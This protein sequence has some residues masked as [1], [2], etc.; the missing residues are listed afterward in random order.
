MNDST[1]KKVF[2]V[3]QA[4]P[5]GYHIRVCNNITEVGEVVKEMAAQIYILDHDAIDFRDEQ[6]MIEYT[7]DNKYI[8]VDE[9]IAARTK[10]H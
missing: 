7:E 5:Y 1:N 6:A 3:R 10:A 2:I 9:L 8:S 4:I